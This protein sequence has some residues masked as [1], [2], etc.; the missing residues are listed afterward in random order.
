VARMA[1]LVA[2]L[3]GAE[4]IHDDNVTGVQRWQI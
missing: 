4:V 3:V 1:L 2:A